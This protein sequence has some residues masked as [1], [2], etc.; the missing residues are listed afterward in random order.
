MCAN[1]SRFALFPFAS[2][3]TNRTSSYVSYLTFVR[4]IS[5]VSDNEDIKQKQ[6]EADLSAML[7]IGGLFDGVSNLIAKFGELAEKG[8]S[9]RAAVGEG[10]T[11]SGK[12]FTTSYGVNVRFGGGRDG[13]GK[14]GEYSVHPVQKA[15]KPESKPA[16]SVPRV[17][18]PNVELYDEG[19]HVQII[20]EMPGVSSED[21]H[22]AFMEKSLWIQGV[23]KVAEFKKELTL[24]REFGPEQVSITAN[25]GVVEIRLSNK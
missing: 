11:S 16:T 14:D 3:Q 20:A 2:V 8:E 9:L 21:V 25:N 19:D 24:P 17:R 6:S 15:S 7:G 1:C 22:L 13:A 4:G 10:E 18:E 12:K 5:T 23:S